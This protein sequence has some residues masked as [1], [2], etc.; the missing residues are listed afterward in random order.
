M[1]LA[2]SRR[3]LSLEGAVALIL[4][5]A[6]WFGAVSLP[7]IP[8]S[9][10]S[11]PY[12]AEAVRAPQEI[13]HVVDHCLAFIFRTLFGTPNYGELLSNN[14]LPI[15]LGYAVFAAILLLLPSYRNA[16]RDSME[17]V[18]LVMLLFPLLF[19]CGVWLF[20]MLTDIFRAEAR[21]PV[22]SG[23]ALARVP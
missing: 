14:A 16:V 17:F 18:L 22:G 20:V 4:L 6:M 13:R 7:S 9:L 12:Y 19:F 23:A 2:T 21:L 15:S 11:I 3:L 1:R 5:A 8:Q 10:A